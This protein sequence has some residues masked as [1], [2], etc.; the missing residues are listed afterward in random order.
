MKIKASDFTNLIDVNYL[1]KWAVIG[2]LIGIIAGGGSIAFYLAIQLVTEYMLGYGA[3]YLP[4]APAGE[5]N[6]LLPFISRPWMIP[7]ITTAGGLSSGLIIRFFAPEAEG[8]GTDAAIDAFHNKAG[9]IRRRIPP[10]K[11]IASAITIQGL[12]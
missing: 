12:V 1:R 10:V 8:H 5:G 6:T 9:A 3:G 4:P 11:L 2:V 7:A